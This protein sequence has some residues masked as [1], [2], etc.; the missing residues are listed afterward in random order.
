M[1]Q[2]RYSKR[3]INIFL[4]NLKNKY[5]INI[6]MIENHLNIIVVMNVR[7]NHVIL[8]SNVRKRKNR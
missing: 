4:K 2:I 1:M 6:K 3:G 5:R 8:E 7:L